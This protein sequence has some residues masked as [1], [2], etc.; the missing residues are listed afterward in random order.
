MILVGAFALAMTFVALALLLNSVV[1]TENLA[2]RDSDGGASEAI[3]YRSEAETSVSGIIGYVNTNVPAGSRESEFLAAMND[4]S[5]QT[6]RYSSIE[7]DMMRIS[8][9]SSDVVLDSNDMIEYVDI[10]VVYKSSQTYYIVDVRVQ[11]P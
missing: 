7:G 3:E 11:A 8:A 10:E 4:W 1:Y 6:A 5:D 9:G 2:S